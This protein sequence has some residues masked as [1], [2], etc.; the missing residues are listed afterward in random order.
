MPLTPD[1]AKQVH[2]NGDWEFQ[3]D[4]DGTQTLETIAPD[5][6]IV[7]PMPWQAAFPELRQY[8]GYAWYRRTFS[9]DAAF[10]AGDARLHFGAVDYWCE[11]W[12]NGTHLGTHEGGYTP[13]AYNVGALLQA[14]D[15][16]IV[17]R[18][19]DSAH[20]RIVS[21]RWRDHDREREA[22]RHGPPF[23]AQ[24][25][26]HGKQEW[27]IN[28]G[29]I[30]Q[31]VT[32]TAIPA[33]SIKRIHVTPNVDAGT[34]TVAVEL[35]GEL[36]ALGDATLT[37][38]ITNG[39]ATIATANVALSAAGT[40]FEATLAIPDAQ[41]WT[42]ETPHLYE[43]HATLA[44]GGTS[45][46]YRVRFGMRSIAYRNGQFILNGEPIYLLSAL[47]QDLYPDTIYTVP[48]EEFMRDQFR[49]AKELGLNSLRCHIKPPDPIYLDLADEMGLLIWAEVPSWRTF[50]VRG[51]LEPD[52]L[53]LPDEL[54][55]RVKAT[56]EGIVERDFNHP[57]LM[58]WT[59][60]NEDWGTST[61]LHAD[62]RAWVTSLYDYCKQIDPTRLVVDNSPC[63]HAWGPNL[64]TKSDIDDFHIYHAIPDNA[65]T[66]VHT[67]EQLALRPLWTYSSNGDAQRRGDEPIVLSEFGN[68]GLPSLKALRD[69]HGGEPHWFDLGPWWSDWGGEPGW[70]A[71]VEE[72]FQQ[73][74][75]SAIWDDYE[76]FA[77]ATQHHQYAAMKLEIEAMRRLPSIAGYVITEFTDAYWESNGLLDFAR[78]PKVYH[79]VFR[80]INSPDVVVAFPTR[81]TYWS[82]ENMRVKITASHYS[83][84]I[85]AG[86][87]LVWRLEGTDQHGTMPLPALARGEV[88][89]VATLRI[90][91]PDVTTTSASQLVLELRHDDTVFAQNT[92]DLTIYPTDARA[93]RVDATLAV[94]G[95]APDDPFALDGSSLD[96]LEPS[97]DD[98]P[99]QADV[100]AIP[101]A[102]QPIITPTAPA[103]MLGQQLAGAGYATTARLQDA[104][105][106]V[107]SYATP[108]LLQWVRD[109]G[110]LLFLTDGPSP[111]FW[112]QGRG[113][114]YSGNWVTSYS[115][116]KPDVHPH[117]PAEN[118]LGMAFSNIMPVGTIVGVPVN[119]PAIQ[120]DLLAGMLSGWVHH[121]AT[122]TLQFRYGRG[123]VLMTTFRLKGMLSS[124]PTAMV[125]LH[126]LIE[127]L[128]SDRC[129][130]T[131]EANY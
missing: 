109:G 10:L 96:E 49:K 86:T 53:Q 17:V 28:V 30:W 45:A 24:H 60:V 94:V 113:G 98:A 121:P 3:L 15:N 125:M 40:S 41:L 108:E 7:V 63:L 79:D 106:A 6:T 124:D 4:P 5:R 8:S 89:D 58:I 74:G 118:P 78:N 112:V 120:S 130:P 69:Y 73:L 122:H 13:F 92:L 104:K 116:I 36:A 43:A 77:I 93:P 70:P 72:R 123:R 50:W 44:A 54:K 115:W 82:G 61:P 100:P 97:G 16:T 29:G 52:Q 39:G 119:D 99:G 48:S 31:D 80:H 33:T 87:Q 105:L 75:L 23:D 12:V 127:Y 84:A 21:E 95:S 81:Y 22:A 2:L 19:Y 68:W 27:Y 25:I 101:A 46:S 26:P 35:D 107:A 38:A 18:V 114:A 76:A 88:A 128:Q 62:D 37:V 64:H 1:N 32:L 9:V 103:S 71:R 85:D 20:E 110:D 65:R 57:S 83:G 131:L 117:L 47:D 51:T 129:Q 111:F 56:L 11:V 126:D 66:F 67:V 91:A 34:A 14:G 59:I 90:K 55:A 42:M 102:E